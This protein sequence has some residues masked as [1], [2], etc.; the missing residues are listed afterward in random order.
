MK[1]F[2]PGLFAVIT[3][4]SLGVVDTAVAQTK[5]QTVGYGNAT[6]TPDQRP[7]LDANQKAMLFTAIR[8]SGT[9]VTPPLGNFPLAVGADIPSGMDLYALPDAALK[10]VPVAK[11]YKFTIINDTLVLVDPAS[12]Q[13]VATIRQ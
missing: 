5:D 12:M 13:V 10:H 2:L 9:K 4:A 1:R 8:R 6:G 11:S 3:L 7:T